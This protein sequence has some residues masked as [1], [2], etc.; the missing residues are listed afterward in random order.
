LIL[1]APAVAFPGSIRALSIPPI[2]RFPES[3]R[4]RGRINGIVELIPNRRTAEH[5]PQPVNCPFL[6]DL[7][8]LR[9]LHMRFVVGLRTTVDT[10]SY[11]SL[12]R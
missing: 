12:E 10:F 3:I 5:F 9:R 4:N 11:K 8:H 1:A 6:F 7:R 2:A